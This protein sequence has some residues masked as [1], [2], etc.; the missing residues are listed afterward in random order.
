MTSRTTRHGIHKNRWPLLL[1][2]LFTHP[3]KQFMYPVICIQFRMK[4]NSQ[5]I[6]ITH[7]HDPVLYPGE[8][9]NILPYRFHVGCTDKGHGHRPDFPKCLIHTKAAK[10]SAIGI[11]SHTNRQG[12]QPDLVFAVDIFRQE[13]QSRT[14]AKNRQSLL[15]SCPAM[16]E[17]S[18]DPS[19]VFPAPYSPRR[20]K[21]PHRIPA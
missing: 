6:P 3:K 8:Y 4:R 19:G 21:S 16:V 15:Y 13:N 18:P 20:A 9:L 14:G 11:A 10:L 1:L 2:S 12:T 17:A 5:L 7:S